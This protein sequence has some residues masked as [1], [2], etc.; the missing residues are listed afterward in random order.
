MSVTTVSE[1]RTTLKSRLRRAERMQR[2]RALGLVL[3]LFLFILVVFVTPIAILLT[4]AVDNPEI[5]E[6]LPLTS[7]ALKDWDGKDIPGEAVYAAFA[8]DLKAAQKSKAIQ[9][10]SSPAR[11]RPLRS[12][13]RPSA[14]MSRPVARGTTARLRPLGGPSMNSGRGHAQ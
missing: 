4:R 12:R 9:K 1:D 6:N 11:E 5:A 7:A 13:C 14:A 10:R 8:E 3:P 2:L